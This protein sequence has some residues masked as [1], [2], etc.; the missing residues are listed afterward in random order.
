MTQFVSETFNVRP[1]FVTI[2]T[3]MDTSDE[4]FNSVPITAVTQALFSNLRL[5]RIG[6]VSF[7]ICS[8]P[9]LVGHAFVLHLHPLIVDFS[10]QSVRLQ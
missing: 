7:Q 4:V 3:A 5:L 8:Q 2:Q 1:M 10:S 6:V 9:N